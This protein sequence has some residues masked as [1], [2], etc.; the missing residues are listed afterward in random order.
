[1]SSPRTVFS[2]VDYNRCVMNGEESERCNGT[3]ELKNL[4]AYHYH[5][6]KVGKGGPRVM[7]GSQIKEIVEMYRSGL[8]GNEVAKKFGCSKPTVLRYARRHGVIRHEE[9]SQGIKY[10]F[11]QSYLDYVKKRGRVSYSAQLRNKILLRDNHKCVE[12]GYSGEGLQLDHIKP[13][14]IYPELAKD[15]N[16]IRTLCKECHLKKSSSDIKLIIKHFKGEL[17]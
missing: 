4:C 17:V 10:V 5:R 13:R 2:G 8:S 3:L 1:V 6:S 14:S 7:T 9:K 15:E 12:C 11:G 16:N